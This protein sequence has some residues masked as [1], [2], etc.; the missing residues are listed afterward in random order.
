MLFLAYSIN[1]IL[2]YTHIYILE[3]WTHNFKLCRVSN[4]GSHFYKKKVYKLDYCIKLYIILTILIIWLYS[5]CIWYRDIEEWGIL[6]DLPHTSKCTY[7]YTHSKLAFSHFIFSTIIF[8]F[9]FYCKIY[10]TS[11]SKC[12]QKDTL[13][14]SFFDLF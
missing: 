5:I 9:V 14:R 1:L 4:Y 12:K 10:P 7:I 6:Y 11:S 2:S 3:V 13:R 8:I